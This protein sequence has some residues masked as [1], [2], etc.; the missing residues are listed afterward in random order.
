MASIV[1]YFLV[2]IVWIL[3]SGAVTWFLAGDI[4]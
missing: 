3:V 4:E 2:G 1:V